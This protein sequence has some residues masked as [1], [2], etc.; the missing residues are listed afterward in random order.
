ME[1]KRYL[2]PEEVSEYL[3]ISLLCAHKIFND[4]N[5]DLARSGRAPDSRKV[6]K[7]DLDNFVFSCRTS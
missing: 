7:E 2:T 3:G 5:E 4:L 6:K 1:S